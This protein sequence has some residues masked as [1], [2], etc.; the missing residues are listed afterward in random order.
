VRLKEHSPDSTL[1]AG[2]LAWFDDR[3]AELQPAHAAEPDQA[4]EPAQAAQ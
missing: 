3:I 4:A 1:L 2:D